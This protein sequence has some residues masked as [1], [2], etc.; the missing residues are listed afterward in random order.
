MNSSFCRGCRSLPADRERGSLL[1]VAMLLA[2]VIGIS[3]ASYIALN[4]NSLKLANRSFYNNGAMNIAETGVEEALWSFNQVTAG[5]AASTAWSGWDVSDGVS[6]N[7]TFT[8][9]TL[10]GGNTASVKVYVDRYNPSSGSV[11]P[12]I[13]TRATITLANE[14]RTLSKTL[15]VQI[16]RRSKFSMG[17]VAKNQITFNGNTASVDSWNSDPDNNPGTASVPYGTGVRHDSGSVGSTSVAVGSLAV[18]NADIWGFASVGGSSMTSLSVGSIGTVA[19]FGSAAG[20]VD[21]TRIAT[22][23]TANFDVEPAPS[24]GLTTLTSMPA[25]L[26]AGTYRYG[27]LISD[28]VTISG[29]VILVLTAAAG[30]DA[31]R[32]TGGDAL[33]LTVGS[34][35][36]IYTAADVKIAGNGVV[37]PTLSPINVQIWG[38]G[39]TTQ[40]I[41]ISGG[42]GYTGI[43]YAPNATVK[44]NG[45]VDVRGSVVANNIIVVGNSAFH[46]DESLA[47][48]GGDNA[49]GVTRWRE[50]ITA[51]DR[52]LYASRLS[53]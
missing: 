33:T 49:Y 32:L 31:I 12:I 5:V 26:P 4:Q 18:N 39:S 41:Q 14:T 46:Y 22:D 40:D 34:S 23:F 1:I 17:L 11:Q 2:S 35:L 13:A 25:I 28:S 10:S 27:G 45:G 48:F 19:A 38:T 50:L 42:S 3:L 7:R 9:F 15:E 47:N 24:A 16:K 43:V 30:N 21:T 36:K 44:L 29:D 53:P 37:N 6:A 20:T 51:A 52:T 8:N